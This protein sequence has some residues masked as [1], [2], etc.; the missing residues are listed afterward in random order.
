M[1]TSNN[2]WYNFFI[3]G[4]SGLFLLLIGICLI[5]AAFLGA[6]TP[7]LITGLSKSY[8]DFSLFKLAIISL[9]LNFLWVYLNRVCYQLL[10]NKYV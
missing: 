5:I 4:N 7:T 8:E 3:F 10:I 9:F 6:Q 2:K 1:N